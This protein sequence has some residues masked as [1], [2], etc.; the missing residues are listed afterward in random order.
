MLVVCALAAIGAVERLCSEDPT[1]DE[2]L[3]TEFVCIEYAKMMLALF[4]GL[5][6]IFVALAM[7][8]SSSG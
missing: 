6:L 2:D 5:V 7:G 3:T 4:G 8:D 1:T